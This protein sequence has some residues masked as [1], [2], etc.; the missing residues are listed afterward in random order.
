VAEHF[1]GKEGVVSSILTIGSNFLTSSIMRVLAILFGLVIIAL[2]VAG[3]TWAYFFY[4][5]PPQVEHSDTPITTFEDSSH[6]TSLKIIA[7]LSDPLASR[8]V[9]CFHA[10]CSTQDLPPNILNFAVSDGQNWYYYISDSIKTS[11]PNASIMPTPVSMSH[12]TGTLVR[13]SSGQTPETV[14]GP[15]DLTAPRGLFISPDNQKLAFF[16]DNIHEPSKKLTELWIYDFISGNVRLVGENYYYPD[17]RS[18]VRW[19]SASSHLYFIGDTGPQSDPKDKLEL[20]I[21]QTQPPTT[22]VAFGDVPWDELGNNFDRHQ[23]DISRT[24]DSLVYIAKSFFGASVLTVITPSDHQRTTVRGSVPFVQ[25]LEDGRLIYAV[26]DQQGFTFWQRTPDNTHRFV[27]RRPGTVT[28]A[29]SDQSGEYVVFAV[30]ESP[31]ITRFYSLKIATGTITDEGKIA[32]HNS[33]VELAYVRQELEETDNFQTAVTYTDN[34]IAAFIEKNQKNIIG[35]G[36]RP[37]RLIPTNLANN[38]FLDY[39]DSH[40]QEHRILLKINDIIHHEWVIKGRYEAVAGAWR[41]IEGGGMADPTPVRLYE[42]EEH[43]N[44]WIQKEVKT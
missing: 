44:Q 25:W 23:I 1:H 12:L 21:I 3:F 10:Q 41:K 15:T 14:I 24:G 2:I 5:S 18:S 42:W 35:E 28:S 36:S 16:R 13:A 6:A 40:N 33:P 43:L 17:I 29:H 7:R 27:A 20:F 22:R 19:N 31:G 11:K 26:Q 9:T 30:T 37:Y 32:N 34:E 8:A 38:I 39:Y 4:F